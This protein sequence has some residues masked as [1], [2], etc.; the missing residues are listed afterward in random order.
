VPE[1]L[2]V[3]HR[4]HYRAEKMH[5]TL[6]SPAPLDPTEVAV[7]ANFGRVPSRRPPR[8]GGVVR[9]PTLLARVGDMRTM[10]GAMGADAADFVPPATPAAAAE[11]G[12]D[13]TRAVAREAGAVAA[14][15]LEPVGTSPMS[16]ADGDGADSGGGDD[17]TWDPTLW[18]ES[19]PGWT[20]TINA[21][22]ASPVAAVPPRVEKPRPRGFVHPYTELLGG[23][24]A[25]PIVSVEA[26]A[27]AHSITMLWY[28]CHSCSFPCVPWL[29]RDHFSPLF[30]FSPSGRCRRRTSARARTRLAT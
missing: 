11:V 29:V 22:P 27:D 5:L 17:N 23:G 18:P 21:V 14:A 25:F 26:I 9:H 28:G 15:S 20:V 24:R 16:G 13:R 4:E 12:T 7:V 10:A 8:A 1:D 6:L 19:S 2:R 30:R 3:F